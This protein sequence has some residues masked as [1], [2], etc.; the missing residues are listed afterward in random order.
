MITLLKK[1]AI[2]KVD[3]I[4][5]D[6]FELIYNHSYQLSDRLHLIFGVKKTNGTFSYTDEPV[7]HFSKT[8]KIYGISTLCGLG[9][10]DYSVEKIGYCYPTTDSVIISD[11]NHDGGTNRAFVNIECRLI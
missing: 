1:D 7:V 2:K 6:G 9:I 3:V 4:A 10:T 11:R 8:T 5:N